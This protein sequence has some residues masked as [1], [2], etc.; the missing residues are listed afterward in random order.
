MKKQ[1]K[2]NRLLSLSMKVLLN[3]NR[4]KIMLNLKKTRNISYFKPMRKMMNWYVKMKIICLNLTKRMKVLLAISI[5]MLFQNI[6]H[7]IINHHQPF[8]CFVKENNNQSVNKKNTNMNKGVL[9][10]EYMVTGEY[11]NTDEYKTYE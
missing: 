7:C 4:I 3:L 1:F 10:T 6:W 9:Y 11:I 2:I 8:F 5:L